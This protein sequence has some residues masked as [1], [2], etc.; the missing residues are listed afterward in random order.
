MASII[1]DPS[2]P[3]LRGFL[4]TL[5]AIPISQL[6][7]DERTCGICREAYDSE[8]TL[9]YTEDLSPA[10]GTPFASASCYSL[11]ELTSSS[12]DGTVLPDEIIVKTEI[13][14]ENH[15]LI[16]SYT[17]YHRC[18]DQD[19]DL[20]GID[21]DGNLSQGDQAVQLPCGHV[22]GRKCLQTW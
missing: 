3:A 13:W 9:D 19:S 2:R 5:Q 6:E 15:I 1:A 22:F 20:E 16:E 11:A 12:V 4:N 7:E 10:Q 18:C 14:V 8:S 17:L 21:L